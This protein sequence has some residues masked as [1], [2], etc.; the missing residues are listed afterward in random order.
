MSSRTDRPTHP[1]GASRA[2]GVP[3]S[4]K[5]A[6]PVPDA[7]TTAAGQKADDAHLDGL[8]TYCLS[9]LHDHDLARTALV[10]V[11]ALATRH[12][13]RPSRGPAG[14][15][16]WLYALA[17]WVCLRELADAQARRPPAHAAPRATGAHG[18][19][20][21]RRA[22]ELARLAWPEAAGTTP[23]Q[24]EALELSVRHGLA[25]EEIAAVLAL[26]LAATRALLAAASC[27]VERTRAALSVVERGTC[28][29]VAR[30][31]GDRRVL[32][33]TA[34][35][36]ELVRHVDDCPR[37][38]RAAERAEAAAPWPG[39]A[40]PVPGPLPLVA[41]DRAGLAAAFPTGARP[42]RV[43][44]AA[45]RFNR[46]GF[47]MD[48]K[49]RAARR[50]RLR[51]RAVTTTLIATVAAAPVLALWAAYRGA[52]LTGE[53]QGGRAVAADESGGPEASHNPRADGHY[54][55]TGSARPTDRPDV[56][57]EVTAPGLPPEGS[58]HGALAVE[59]RHTRVGT[60]IVLTATGRAPVDWS[61]RAGS[62]WLGLSRTSGTLAPGETVTLRVLVHAD[63][64]PRGYWAARIAIGPHGAVVTVRGYGGGTPGRPGPTR[65]GTNPPVPSEPGPTDPGSPGPTDPGPTDP[66]PTD[67]GPTDPD[68]TDPGPT[69]PGPTDPGPTDPGPT[70]PGP[71]DPGPI[72]S[73]PGP[74]EPGPSEPGGGESGGAS[75]AG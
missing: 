29:S 54:E 41:A 30:L 37:C 18:E 22:A 15:R 40:R 10:E 36:T 14:R 39:T 49:D 17:R 7:V 69:D 16:A 58:A 63:R 24:R 46:E 12:G 3:A 72:P 67:P 50:E 53:A 1:A 42:L 73:E 56:S 52:P 55:N 66:G 61:A 8:F 45:P 43:A 4:S 31:T 75:P 11:V 51:A 13:S 19:P 32:L 20:D 59:A 74:S 5:A 57:V 28:P 21:K 71:T 64:E 65:P 62:A 9:I 44:R 70:D 38:R 27:E 33:S 26:D 48:P 60:L 47:P 68:P 35:R 6:G 25:A 2:H 34:L 23:E